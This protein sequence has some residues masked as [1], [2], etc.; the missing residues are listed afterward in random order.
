M[1]MNREERER[2]S[3]R[4]R[5]IGCGIALVGIIL[6]LGALLVSKWIE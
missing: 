3:E 2:N 4:S 5:S 6:C 1:L